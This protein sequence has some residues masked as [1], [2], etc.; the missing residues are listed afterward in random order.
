M[1]EG[2]H[3]SS[4]SENKAPRRIFTAD[5]RGFRKKQ[6]MDGEKGECL[7]LSVTVTA[8][9]IIIYTTKRS[10]INIIIIIIIIIMK[11]CA[12]SIPKVVGLKM[13]KTSQSVNLLTAVDKSIIGLN[14]KIR[15]S[16]NTT[17]LFTVH[18]RI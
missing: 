14:N 16:I 2:G 13:A 15:F 3:R 9:I 8:T 4:V 18:M 6:R 12:Y 5:L 1:F 10:P 11:M 17:I 7:S